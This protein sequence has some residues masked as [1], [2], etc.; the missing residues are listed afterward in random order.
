MDEIKNP[1]KW[2]PKFV[3][4]ESCS[5]IILK[6]ILEMIYFM[7]SSQYIPGETDTNQPGYPVTWSRLKL[8]TFQ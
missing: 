8:G 3:S 6:L 1:Y 2:N 7:I 5:H 4:S